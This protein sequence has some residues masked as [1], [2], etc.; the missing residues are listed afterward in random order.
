MLKGTKKLQKRADA[1]KRS[2]LSLCFRDSESSIGPTPSKVG[3]SSPRTPRF[4][5]SGDV[6]RHE[7]SRSKAC[8]RRDGGHQQ[9]VLDLWPHGIDR[10]LLATLPTLG[11]EPFLTANFDENETP[12]EIIRE[13]VS[14]SSPIGST[15]QL[16][17]AEVEPTKSKEQRAGCDGFWA[18]LSTPF[19]PKKSSSAQQRNASLMPIDMPLTSII[20]PNRADQPF[21]T[22]LEARTT[23]MP[24]GMPKRTNSTPNRLDTEWT[25]SR[26]RRF[27]ASK[28]FNIN[29]PLRA[30]WIVT[31]NE[32]RE[33]WDSA[34]G[35]WVRY[36]TPTPP[37]R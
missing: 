8:S 25:P 20:L 3:L 11:E 35:R 2:K 34:L 18:L 12:F 31:P 4:R 23:D 1:R 27:P 36:T 37:P 5:L 21:P 6:Q 22:P 16:W 32:E 15:D 29:N 19:K 30:S 9:A 10:A 28:S 33:Q 14:K 7:S 17:P 24:G 13:T 26:H